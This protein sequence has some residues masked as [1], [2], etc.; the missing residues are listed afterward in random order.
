MNKKLYHIC[1][2]GQKILFRTE[3]DYIMAI[4]R[5]A[6]CANSTY[7]E[8]WAYSIMSTHFH[9]IIASSRIDDFVKAYKINLSRSHK[10]L[11]NS[12][13]RLKITCR[14]LENQ[15]SILNALNYVLK[16][17]IHH[18]ITDIAFNYPYSS[19]YCYFS[20]S[21]FKPELNS[22][23]NS[24]IST[25][26]Y[27]K[28]GV[29]L[30]RELFGTRK[31]HDDYLIQDFR[32]VLPESFINISAVEKLYNTP[33]RFLY[34][35]TSALKEELEEFGKESD[36]IYNQSNPISLFGKNTDT[37]VCQMIDNMIAPKTYTELNAKEK[38]QLWNALR[39][40]GVDRFQFERAT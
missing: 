27:S 10:R 26:P 12:Y 38:E 22:I 17:P 28:I 36:A 32:F 3:D 13:I 7:T 15:Y 23:Q 31:L 33:R 18:G 2:L 37:E 19:A 30:S 8:V 25:C 20:D 5:L 35:M 40:Q 16:N 21:I 24:K 39:K 11:Y 9:L 1:N 29:N 14:Y 6:A 34:N 4:N